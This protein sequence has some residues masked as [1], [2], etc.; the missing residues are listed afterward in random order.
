MKAR[1]V[2]GKR[3]VKIYQ[4]RVGPDSEYYGP[5]IV[6]GQIELEDGTLL[7]A[8]SYDTTDIPIASIEATQ[9]IT[10]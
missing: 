4:E 3:I 8:H 9:R 5:R 1:D 6:C 7:T 10:K 2:V